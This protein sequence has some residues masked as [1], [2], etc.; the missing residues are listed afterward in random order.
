MNCHQLHSPYA[1]W[2]HRYSFN[3]PDNQTTEMVHEIRLKPC[4]H[5]LWWLVGLGMPAGMLFLFAFGAIMT[6]IILR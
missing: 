6:R 2:V 1:G 5:P 3:V 4:V